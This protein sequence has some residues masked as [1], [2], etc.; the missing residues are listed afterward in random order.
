[1]LIQ[2]SSQIK[3]TL[4][5]NETLF[6]SAHSRFVDLLS[7]HHPRSVV[8]KALFAT[9]MKNLSIYG[10]GAKGFT[11]SAIETAIELTQGRISTSELKELLE[12]GKYILAHPVEVLEAVPDVLEQLS[13]KG[14]T[15]LL[16]TKGDLLHQERK[17]AESGLAH[18]FLATE[19]VSEKDETTYS[20]LLKRHGIEPARFLMVG[21]SLKSDIAPVLGIGGMAAHI[22]YHLTWEAEKVEREPE[23]PGR[24]FTLGSIRELPALVERLDRGG[25]DELS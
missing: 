4:W 17:I 18:R 14:H 1:M 25:G 2:C 16:I 21:N 11:L 7:T 22:P 3:D 20:K 13:T 6:T 24:Y 19:V 12:L 8:E 9:E 15:M 23:A 10:Y 5:H